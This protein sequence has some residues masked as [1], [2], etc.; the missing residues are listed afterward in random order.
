MH[1]LSGGNMSCLFHIS[2][3]KKVLAENILEE[4]TVHICA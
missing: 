2:F 3:R 4:R 1:L